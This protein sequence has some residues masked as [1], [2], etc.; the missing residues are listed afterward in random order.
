M[1]DEC[2]FGVGRVRHGFAAA[3]VRWE[4]SALTAVTALVR[5][6]ESGRCSSTRGV[7]ALPTSPPAGLRPGGVRASKPAPRRGVL[8]GQAETIAR[9]SDMTFWTRELRHADVDRRC[10][11]SHRLV[12]DSQ[13]AGDCAVAHPEL[14]QVLRLLRDLQVDR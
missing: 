9:S 10:G 1:G 2:S 14:A 7:I 12:A 3:L 8:A 13:C 4:K 11:F 6:P 5:P